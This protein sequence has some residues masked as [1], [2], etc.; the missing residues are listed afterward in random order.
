MA[1]KQIETPYTSEAA[2]YIEEFGGKI[3]GLEFLRD[4]C[5]KLQES[6]LPS[7][8][9]KPGEEYSGHLPPSEGGKYIVRGSHP[10]DII[11]LVDVIETR[12][13]E[14]IADIPGDIDKIRECARQELVMEY[15]KYE[16]P[17]YDGNV[18]VAIQ[19]RLLQYNDSGSK[20]RR[21]GSI[22]DHPDSPG[23]YAVTLVNDLKE[24][25]FGNIPG[26]DL[27]SGIDTDYFNLLFER[28]HDG[29]LQALIDM[30]HEIADSGLIKPGFSFQVEFME[31]K[32]ESEDRP[33]ICQVRAFRKKQH[34][35]DKKTDLTSDFLLDGLVFGATPPEGIVLPVFHYTEDKKTDNS[36]H[37]IDRNG[38]WAL[39]RT[40]H[41]KR[42]PLT[43]KPK[44][45]K[46]YL[47]S[48]TFDSG[49][50]SLEHHQFHLAQTADVAF[51]E[52]TVRNDHLTPL[53]K[54]GRNFTGILK[55]VRARIIAA[56]GRIVVKVEK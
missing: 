3:G 5:P 40:K 12:F 56:A 1:F 22:V 23:N 36:W 4:R 2:P 11:R 18:V 42:M 28:A 21:R 31:K 46:A 20:L 10:L 24:S 50:P 43:F 37:P 16:D 33:I 15:G 9:V 39:L 54:A 13:P 14:K 49:K 44:K 53:L 51:L 17:S 8:I 27:G 32:M 25:A 19:P 6:I 26:M 30:H 38:P 55:D 45:L 7:T 48:T 35:I 47:A 41:D 34:A 29:A 52:S